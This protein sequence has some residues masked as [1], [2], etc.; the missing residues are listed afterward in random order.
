MIDKEINPN[1]FE[2]ILE[3]IKSL[4][5]SGGGD[6]PEDEAGGKLKV[7]NLKWLPGINYVIQFADAPTH[8]FSDK[9]EDRFHD[10]E[11]DNYVGENPK[12]PKNIMMEFKKMGIKILFVEIIPE[13]TKKMVKKYKNYIPGLMSTIDFSDCKDDENKIK[14]NIS[15]LLIPKIIGLAFN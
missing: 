15:E 4:K 5:F 12:H 11:L 1:G 7:L 14:D 2:N 8:N 13:S 9:K 3:T 10:F 6:I